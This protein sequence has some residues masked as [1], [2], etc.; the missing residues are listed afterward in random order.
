MS[1]TN[2]Y[3]ILLII[4]PF[5]VFARATVQMCC[6]FSLSNLFL[7]RKQRRDGKGCWIGWS[8]ELTLG[9]AARVRAPRWHLTSNEGVISREY[10]RENSVPVAE[11]GLRPPRP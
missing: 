2:E 9:H 5:A 7:H 6:T 11:I 1:D 10:H 3:T 4:Q 8:A